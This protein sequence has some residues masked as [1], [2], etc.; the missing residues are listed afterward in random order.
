MGPSALKADA[1]VSG[2]ATAC[3]NFPVP[4]GN[5][6]ARQWRLLQMIQRPG[7]VSIDDAAQELE[8]TARTIWRDLSALQTAGFPLYDDKAA[9]GRR[10]IWKLEDKFTLGLPVK[11]TLAETATLVM[12]RDLLRPAGVGALGSALASAF[13]K[14]GRVLS[15]D[16]VRVL[17]QMR[18][19]IGVR[20][21]GAK[22]QAPAAEH[23]A[24]IEQALHERPPRPKRYFSLR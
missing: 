8:C 17:D 10:S 11:L 13:D 15:R 23:V 9:D 3:N 7:G 4:R 1:E 20:A 6:L 5:Q 19:T 24:L 22:L 18:E 12:S 14:I 21:V 16:A 2:K